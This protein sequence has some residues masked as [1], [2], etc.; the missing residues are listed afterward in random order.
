M[1][2]SFA[3]IYLQLLSLLS[4]AASFSAPNN[5]DKNRLTRDSNKSSS[6][7]PSLTPDERQA[8]VLKKMGYSWNGK[9][10]VRGDSKSYNQQRAS[11]RSSNRFIR[12][13]DEHNQPTAT[14]AAVAGAKRLE[15]VLSNARQGVILRDGVDRSLDRDF[16][17]LCQKKRAPFVWVGVELLGFT[18]LSN[19]RIPLG[20][21]LV[22]IDWP[23]EIQK[24]TEELCPSVFLG[25]MAGVLLSQCR[26]SSRQLLPGVEELDGKLVR[27]LADA[28]DGNFALPAPNHVRYTSLNWKLFSALGEIIAAINITVLMNG[29]LQPALIR[30]SSSGGGVWKLVSATSDY[31]I[32]QYIGLIG[33]IGSAFLVAIPAGL[34]VYTSIMSEKLDGIPAECDA[35][36]RG[37]KTAG[38]Y[39]NMNPPKGGTDPLEA[40][41][42]FILLADGWIQKFGDVPSNG[43]IWKQP[44]LAYFGSLACAMV[45]QLSGGTLLAPFL[46]RFVAAGSS[47]FIYDEREL[48][49]VSLLL[50]TSSG[51]I[52]NS[53]RR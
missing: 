27:I 28:I 3:F 23:T 42:S 20:S 45:W 44:V 47:Y 12:F 48:C 29:L 24:G 2:S 25:I 36:L 15:E 32:G 16:K 4:F 33:G 30:V 26:A 21:G 53:T 34:R 6:P 17:N 1:K 49:R 5:N 50:P 52:S 46:A 7:P 18:A 37:R 35:L 40:T 41:N 38:A 51:K 31:E 19:I 22:S 13:V 8:A 14:D 39:F 11:A 9:S 43:A 10:W